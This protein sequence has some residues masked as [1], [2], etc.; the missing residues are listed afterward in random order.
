MKSE[1]LLG[2]ATNK[3]TETKQCWKVTDAGC[4]GAKDGVSADQLVD[5]PPHLPLQFKHLRDALLDI[6]GSS[7]TLCQAGSPTRK[8]VLKRVRTEKNEINRGMKP[9]QFSLLCSW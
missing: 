3:N 1:I 7:H 5:L 6:L 2:T 9:D 8:E 4:R